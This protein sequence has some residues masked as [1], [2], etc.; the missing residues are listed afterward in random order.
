M[1]VRIF[2]G[3]SS[4]KVH[5]II[6]FFLFLYLFCIKDES[7]LTFWP[8][9]SQ[10]QCKIPWKIPLGIII[11]EYTYQHIAVS[12]SVDKKVPLWIILKFKVN[13]P[14][15]FRIEDI[16]FIKASVTC[17]LKK[18]NWLCSLLAYLLLT[19]TARKTLIPV[20]MLLETWATQHI[21]S[22]KISS[23]QNKNNI[24]YHFNKPFLVNMIMQLS[25]LQPCQVFRN[26]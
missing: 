23:K 15:S 19:L 22:F 13:I 21:K 14:H 18:K 10:Q 9:H 2:H 16:L 26:M 5:D 25:Y 3:L 17:V 24:N 20:W 8:W 12:C 7:N 4:S 11:F 6:T 1:E